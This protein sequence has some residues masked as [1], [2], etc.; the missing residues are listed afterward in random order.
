MFNKEDIV[1][2]VIHVVLISTF[3]GIFFF[4]YGA[5]IE[6]IIVQKQVAFLL[7]GVKPYVKLLSTDNKSEILKNININNE[8]LLE[9]DKIVEKHNNKLLITASLT[10]IGLFVAGAIFVAFM[11]YRYKQE[12]DIIHLLKENGIILFFVAFTYFAFATFFAQFYLPIEPNTI[13]RKLIQNMGTTANKINVV[14]TS[15]N[16][17]LDPLLQQNINNLGAF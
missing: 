11:S 17:E 16:I 15:D 4:T 3:I 8:H 6:G 13:K 7:E 1:N 10:L 9:E 14:N 12:I 2:I 5:Y